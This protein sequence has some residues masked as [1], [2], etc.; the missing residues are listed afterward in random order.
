MAALD[1][2]ILPDAHCNEHVAAEGLD[3]GEPLS[4]A[5]R[6]GTIRVQLALGQPFENLIDQLQTLLD[7]AD[8]DPHPCI[9]VAVV[10]H[11]RIEL[12]LVIGR[13]GHALRASKARP[14]ARPT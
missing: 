13:I 8:A 3:Q 1:Q 7:L 14:E 5:A 10:A 9:D 2:P 11:R 4:H 12:K 6:L